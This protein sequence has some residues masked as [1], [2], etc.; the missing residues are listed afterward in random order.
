MP[1]KLQHVGVSQVVSPL[2]YNQ[3]I[4]P[5]HVLRLHDVDASLALLMTYTADNGTTQPRFVLVPDNTPHHFDLTMKFRASA[6]PVTAKLVDPA[7]LSAPTVAM[8]VD[9]FT[10]YQ[11][12]VAPFDRWVSDGTRLV[13]TVQAADSEHPRLEDAAEQCSGRGLLHGRHDAK[14]DGS[15][16]ACIADGHRLR[17]PGDAVHRGQL[18]P[19]ITP[20]F[21]INFTEELT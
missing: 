16:I 20:N 4:Y 5:G 12:N 10:V 2:L 11:R 18:L 3:I 17:H 8:L 7:L 1:K 19:G 21:E 15:G 13:A 9:T 6:G 14:P